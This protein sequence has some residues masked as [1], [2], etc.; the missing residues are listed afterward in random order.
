MESRIILRS[1]FEF[2]RE[3]FRYILIF[4]VFLL[5]AQY[6][7]SATPMETLKEDNDSRKNNHVVE[8]VDLDTKNKEKTY[9]SIFQ[10]QSGDVFRVGAYIKTKKQE[11]VEVFIQSSLN[12]LL[13]IGEWTLEPSESGEYKELIF[14]PPGRY[15][16]I[17][18]GLKNETGTTGTNKWSGTA[19]YIRSLF[20]TRV[21]VESR[22]GIQN[23]HPTIFG[24]PQRRQV[25]LFEENR[26]TTSKDLVWAFQAQGDFLDAIE[27]S[28]EIIGGG[29]QEYAFELSLVD[30][31]R[32][33]K[34]GGTTR[35][36]SFILDA[37]D[38]Y[39][40]PS[41]NYQVALPIPITRG[42]W[43]ELSLTRVLSEDD[44]NFFNLGT[45]GIRAIGD[46]DEG[47]KEA[48][49]GLL[50]GLLT[51]AEKDETF[52]EYARLE[53]LGNRL[54]Y[55]YSFHGNKADYSNIFSASAGISF[56]QEKGLVIGNQKKNE[57]FEYRFDMVYAFDKFVL[58]ATQQGDDEKE[59]K[60][61]YSFDDTLW[62][63]VPF[64]Q[65]K[66]AP[67][68]FLLE[69]QEEK[70]HRVLYVRV[71]YSG[72]E[73]KSGFFALKTLSVNASVPKL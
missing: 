73:K 41:G 38:D 6:H 42:A 36:V 2:L 27:F 30:P 33:E 43:Y 37:L 67:Q 45:L 50:M 69:L 56:D 20:V 48:S 72:A 34:Q 15:E 71:S 61:E 10:S 9:Q 4:F 29:R 40:L 32:K 39:R 23:L 25:F 11:K 17:I 65:E 58:E 3:N 57:F 62:Y 13:K 49:L 1:V 46:I 24:I 35:S 26:K 63:E 70:K 55:A 64:T 60:L 52:P 54:M 66:G 68:K 51:R 12:D 5:V 22:A 8:V 19:V 28:G 21:T 16:N 18:V 53:D 59:I 47:G 14:S 31:V 7:Y 44:K